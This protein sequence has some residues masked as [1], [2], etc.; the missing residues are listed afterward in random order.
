MFLL[1]WDFVLSTDCEMKDRNFNTA[2]CKGT[3]DTSLFFFEKS[4]FAIDVEYFE[5]IYSR[6]EVIDVFL[7]QDIS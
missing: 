7:G 5:F 6:S 3:V 1:V 4:S 2:S